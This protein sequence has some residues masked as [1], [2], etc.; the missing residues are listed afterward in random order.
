VFDNHALPNA[1]ISPEEVIGEDE[2]H[3]LE[4]LWNQRMASSTVLIVGE[5]SSRFGRKNR[6]VMPSRPSPTPW[7][8]K[9]PLRQIWPNHIRPLAAECGS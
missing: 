7:D 3:R 8:R 5:P 9:H 6:N 4:E 2:R 1:I